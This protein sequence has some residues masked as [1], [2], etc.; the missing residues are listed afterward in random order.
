MSDNLTPMMRQYREAKAAIPADAVLL[1]RLGDFYEEFFED[2]ER[3]SKAL[4]L[5]LT[6][7]QGV[8]MCG[9]PYHAL[10]SYL[11]RLVAAGLKVAVAEQM[12]DPRLAKGIVKRQVTRIITPGT[13]TDQGMLDSGCNNFLVAVNGNDKTTPVL[14]AL[15]VS[16]GEFF[17][18]VPST[19]DQFASELNRL[20]SREFLVSHKYRPILEGTGVLAD[21][22]KKPLLTEL[23]D[24]EFD[25]ADSEKLLLDHFGVATLDGF[26]CRD[27]PEAVGAAGALLRYAIR[28]KKYYD[29]LDIRHTTSEITENEKA[30]KKRHYYKPRKKAQVKNK[31]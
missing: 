22:A 11:P 1:F 5:V 14:A 30:K 20:G 13:I 12:E 18:C 31:Q 28:F 17:I 9:F 25:P 7:R 26:G 16:T 10:E 24:Y 6:R 2:A 29:H 27:L 19:P 3:V 15:D 8:P 23:D 21:A 4:E